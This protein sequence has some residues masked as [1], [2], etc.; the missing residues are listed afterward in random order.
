[1]S[2]LLVVD[3]SEMNRD[4]LSRLLKRKGFEVNTAENGQEALAMLQSDAP[5]L[6]LMDM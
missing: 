2:K 3:D 5:Q 4:V 1:M 6:V